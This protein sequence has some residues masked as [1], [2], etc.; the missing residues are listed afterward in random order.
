MDTSRPAKM[1][2]NGKVEEIKR[3]MPETYKSIQAKAAKIGNVAYELVR[4]GLRGEANCFY[5]FEQARVVG[6]PFNMPDV[7]ADVALC[8][9]E[10]GC[11][12]VCMFGPAK[13]VADGTH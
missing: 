12:Y 2:V 11:A 1:D 5:A 13:E 6:T 9:V 3:F 4:R 7:T 8:I 10:F